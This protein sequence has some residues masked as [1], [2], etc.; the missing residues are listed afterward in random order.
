[1]FGKKILEKD[2]PLLKRGIG[3][4]GTVPHYFIK[5]LSESAASCVKR[6][7]GAPLANT[8]NSSANQPVSSYFASADPA[9]RS[10]RRHGA[11]PAVL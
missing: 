3:G 6:A 1:M 7:P 8:C 9:E 2:F 4:E 5:R 10:L 11:D